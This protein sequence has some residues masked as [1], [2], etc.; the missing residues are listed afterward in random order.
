MIKEINEVL[1]IPDMENLMTLEEIKS[2][3]LEGKGTFGCGPIYQL[4]VE[5]KSGLIEDKT[6]IVLENLNE[7]QISALDMSGY[8]FEFKYPDNCINNNGIQIIEIKLF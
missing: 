7:Q 5:I 6:S 8:D 2:S 1:G 3:I 4:Y